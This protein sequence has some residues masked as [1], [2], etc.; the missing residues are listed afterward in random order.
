MCAF[1]CLGDCVCASMCAHR[2][3][4]A[5]GTD[6]DIGIS[7]DGCPLYS[8]THGLSLDP[9]ITHMVSLASQLAPG[10]VMSSTLTYGVIGR[11]P[12]SP[13]ICVGSRDQSSDPQV[14]SVGIW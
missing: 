7:L 9:E 4:H 14:G 12:C 13:G 8:W 2:C 6:A 3:M 5:W 11:L 1:M 10:G